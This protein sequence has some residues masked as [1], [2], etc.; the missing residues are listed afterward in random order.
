LTWW[1]INCMF[2]DSWLGIRWL[3]HNALRGQLFSLC[4]WSLATH[5]A[6]VSIVLSLKTLSSPMAQVDMK[7]TDCRRKSIFRGQT[8][9]LKRIMWVAEKYFI[10][11]RRNYMDSRFC[12]VFWLMYMLALKK[13]AWWSNDR[14]SVPYQEI[15]NFQKHLKTLFKAAGLP[16]CSSHSVRQMASQWAIR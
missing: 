8:G 4:C 14:S 2:Q 11:I 10:M 1:K 13:E 16:K 7:Q 3:C 9:N 5:L 12:P 15:G 6:W